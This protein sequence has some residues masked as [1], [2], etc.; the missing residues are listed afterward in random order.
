MPVCYLNVTHYIKDVGD[1]TLNQVW[2]SQR[3][4]IQV[5]TLRFLCG[6]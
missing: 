5:G 2:G 1:M 3:G 6:H 4:T